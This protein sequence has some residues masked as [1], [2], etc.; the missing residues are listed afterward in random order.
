MAAL[1]AAI[2]SGFACGYGLT[3]RQGD[4]EFQDGTAALVFQSNLHLIRIDIHVLADHL[5][6]LLLQGRQVVRLAALAALVGDDD[7]QALFCNGRRGFFLAL[8]EEVKNIH[9]RPPNNRCMKPCFFTSRKRCATSLPSR[10]STAS[11]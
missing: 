5:D 11:L 8:A 9:S 2:W 6:Q 1:K 10:R 7:L 3:V 4:I